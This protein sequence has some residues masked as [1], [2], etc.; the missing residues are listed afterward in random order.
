MGGRGTAVVRGPDVA[1]PADPADPGPWLRANQVFL[2]LCAPALLLLAL[3]VVFLVP[4][5]L[6][7]GA[8][9][10]VLTAGLLA[11]P[12]AVLAF[13]RHRRTG[14]PQGWWS[15]WATALIAVLAVTVADPAFRQTTVA[16]LVVGPLYAAMTSTARSMAGHLALTVAVASGLVAVL[17]GD[18]LVRT[19][20]V[21]A[22]DVVL[23]LTVAGLFVLR[24]RLDAAVARAV[25]ARDRADELAARDP[26]TGLLNRRGVRDA[27]AGLGD[28]SVGA[29]LLDVDHFKRVNDTF[30]HG[31]GDEVLVRVAA[32]LAATVRPGDLLARIGGEEF[33]VLAPGAGAQ[34][35][36]ALAERLRVAVAA[37]GGVPPVT[38]SAG[39]AAR[40]PRG[41]V[42]DVLD[43]LY[44]RVDR[45]LYRAKAEGRDRVC[46]EPDAGEVPTARRTVQ[47]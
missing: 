31:A 38:V 27:L 43:E 16:A 32:V 22:V 6:R 40:P 44:A 42:P 26:L 13:V 46:A 34:E 4:D 39:A 17:P 2:L 1:V 41:T 23:V 7:P 18:P 37:D 47:A 5:V 12:V 10:V 25:A 3:A 33:F 11:P 15:V 19:A 24:A 45:L 20:R 36:A 30:G 29:V 8:A 35:V 9:P 28:R 14:R 21:V